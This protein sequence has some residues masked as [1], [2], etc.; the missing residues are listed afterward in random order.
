MLSFQHGQQF[1]VVQTLRILEVVSQLRTERF[2][3]VSDHIEQI[4]DRNNVS[5]PDCLPL[6]HE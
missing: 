5:Q 4:T 3:T 2:I 1:L 6:F